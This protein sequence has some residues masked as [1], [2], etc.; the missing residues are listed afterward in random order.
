MLCM[1]RSEILKSVKNCT[2]ITQESRG[3]DILYK[4]PVRVRG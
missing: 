4:W 1:V 3:I 2:G